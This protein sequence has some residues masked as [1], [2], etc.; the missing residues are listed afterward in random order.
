MNETA[1]AII[2][3]H[4]QN[5]LRSATTHQLDDLVYREPVPRITCRDGTS[6]S[7]QAGKHLYCYP[8]NN[9]GPWTHVEVMTNANPVYFKRGEDTV[10]GYVPIELVAQELLSRGNFRIDYN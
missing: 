2:V 10:V 9:D 4:L 1:I 5:H 8:Q 3:E 7:I 6:F